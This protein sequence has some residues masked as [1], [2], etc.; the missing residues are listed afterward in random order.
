MNFEENITSFLFHNFYN[1]LKLCQLVH[2]ELILSM[3]IED[4]LDQYLRTN[5]TKIK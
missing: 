3:S 2:I 4:I 5:F 1:F